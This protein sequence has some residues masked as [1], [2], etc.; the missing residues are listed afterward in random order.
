MRQRSRLWFLGAIAGSM[1]TSALLFAGSAHA[2]TVVYYDVYG[3]IVVVEED[4][5]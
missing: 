2:D 3:N 5:I 1:T 4:S